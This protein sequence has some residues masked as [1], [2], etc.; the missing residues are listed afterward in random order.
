M[1]RATAQPGRGA[2]LRFPRPR[3][4]GAAFAADDL[5]VTVVERLARCPWKVF[6]ERTLGLAP[7]PDPRATLPEPDAPTVGAVVHGTLQRLVADEPDAARRRSTRSPPRSR[8]RFAGLPARAW[9][10]RR[11]M[12]RGSALEAGITLPGL[13]E[14][15]ARRAIP[16]VRR[17]IELE[18]EGDGPRVLGAE[19]EGVATIAP[20]DGRPVA[21]RFRSDRV[22]RRRGTMRSS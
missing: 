15:L 6:L 20:G 18:W 3:A 16:F 1:G 22:D 4:G 8:S 9:R 2:P 11:A 21:L 12:S 10:R 19:V 5:W 7:P 17:A 13:H 14:A